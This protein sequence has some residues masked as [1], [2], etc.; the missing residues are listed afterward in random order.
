[1]ILPT[2]V[3]VGKPQSSKRC[4]APQKAWRMRSDNFRFADQP[5]KWSRLYHA[6]FSAGV[7]AVTNI[8]GE[9]RYSLTV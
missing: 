3:Y 5:K 9:L 8:S 2:H 7:R 6:L 4:V 1:M